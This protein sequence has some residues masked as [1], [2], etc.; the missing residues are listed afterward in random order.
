[1]DKRLADRFQSDT[2]A[3]GSWVSIGHPTVAELAAMAQPDFI[4]ID[5]EH[6]P[7]SYETAQSMVR[8]IQSLDSR[9]EPVI[10][11]RSNDRSWI[12][13]ALDLGVSSLMVPMI[14]SAAEAEAAV[15]ASRYPPDGNR[16]VAGSRA[17]GFGT[18]LRETVEKANDRIT[19]IA[20][21]ETERA[22]DSVK[23]IAATPGVDALFV[24]PS[25]LTANLG[26]VGEVDRPEFH[27]AVVRIIE[28]G[29]A[30]DVPIG[31]LAIGH[32]QI[33]SQLDLG[34][35]FAIT[36]KDTIHLLDGIEEAVSDARTHSSV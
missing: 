5:L 22:V 35:D 34:F 33:Q 3:V 9:S 21:I 19:L 29:N 17:A 30:S 4:L 24:G 20:Q 26:I 8:A 2:L 31:T 23:E 28:A 25:D 12:Q 32:D 7:I 1:M 16:G 15:A 36:G 11:A 27:E 10:R 13:R 14:N 6:T 18:T